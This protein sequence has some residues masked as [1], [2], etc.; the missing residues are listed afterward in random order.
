M[1][2]DIHWPETLSE[3]LGTAL[4]V[5]WGL[6][7]IARSIGPAFLSSQWQDLWIYILAPALGAIIA[8]QIYVRAGLAREIVCSK[9]Y[10]TKRF[11]CIMPGCSF[12]EN[13][14]TGANK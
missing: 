9:L 8:A 4:M 10:H 5:G 14:E 11:K 7:S 6:S 3:F 13:S 1:Q 12:G 2:S